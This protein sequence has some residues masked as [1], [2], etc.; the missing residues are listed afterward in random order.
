M[1][2]FPAHLNL[3]GLT[4]RQIMWES[5][6]SA[7]TPYKCDKDSNTHRKRDTSSQLI[8]D[9]SGCGANRNRMDST[10]VSVPK[11]RKSL[12]DCQWDPICGVRYGSSVSSAV[13]PVRSV[14]P[15]RRHRPRGGRNLC[16]YPSVSSYTFLFTCVHWMYVVCVS[17]CATT[18]YVCIEQRALKWAS[19]RRCHN[20]LSRPMAR[21]G[22]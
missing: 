13:G 16:W 18:P 22:S 6:R 15:S 3:L 1:I 2:S 10:S 21:S 5:A 14:L 12:D 8:R 20:S 17:Q 4:R 19:E 7:P 11:S 9:T